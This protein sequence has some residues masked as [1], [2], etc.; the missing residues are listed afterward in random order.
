MTPDTSRLKEFLSCRTGGER[1]REMGD[2][3]SAGYKEGKRAGVP[4]TGLPG[5]RP[6]AMNDPT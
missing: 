2:L 5:H 1:G 3:Q 4:V 6:M